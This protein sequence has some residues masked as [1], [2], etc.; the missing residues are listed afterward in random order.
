MDNELYHYGRKGMKWYQN[1][2]TSGKKSISRKSSSSKKKT[3]TKAKTT[4]EK[5]KTK[6]LSEMSDAELNQIVNRKRLEDQYKSLFPKKVSM[7]ERVVKTV[8]NQVVVPSAVAAGKNVLTEAL[9]SVGKELIKS[10][11][12]SQNN[13]KK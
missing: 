13:K 12:V 11:N 4:E 2:Y 6:T 10:K 9:T 5:P 3:Q 7:G 1:I 8:L